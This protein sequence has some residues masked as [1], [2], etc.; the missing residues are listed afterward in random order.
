MNCYKSCYKDFKRLNGVG[1][2][3]LQQTKHWEQNEPEMFTD[4]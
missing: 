3:H 2:H 1:S 4:S